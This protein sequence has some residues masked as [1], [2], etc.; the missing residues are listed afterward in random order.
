MG[1]ELLLLFMVMLTLGDADRVADG[2]SAAVG[3]HGN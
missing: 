1:I 3:A 2:D